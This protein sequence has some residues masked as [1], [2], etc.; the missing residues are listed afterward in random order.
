MSQQTPVQDRYGFRELV[1]D[2]ILPAALEW[3]RAGGQN[4][5]TYV[6]PDGQNH[7]YAYNPQPTRNDDP[8]AKFLYGFRFTNEQMLLLAI[9]GGLAIYL[10]KS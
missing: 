3:R 10:V 2:D 1:F 6:G 7:S 4:P 8:Q 9:A 5:N